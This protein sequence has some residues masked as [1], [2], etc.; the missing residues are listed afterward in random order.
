V[1]RAGLAVLALTALAGLAACGDET[2]TGVGGGL[3][4]PGG[5]VRTFEVFLDGAQYLVRDT[6]FGEYSD[7]RDANFVVVARD[8]EGVLN[9]NA[10]ARFSLPR[11]VTVVDTLGTTQVD[12]MPTYLGGSL[13]VFVDTLRS[14]PGP[15]RLAIYR[16]AERWDESATWE[17][18]RD[19][20]GVRVPWTQP[21]GTRGVFIDTTVYTS[22]RDTLVFDVDGATMAAWA[23]TTDLDR[24]VLIV[25]E[26]AGGRV[27]TS[28]PTLT[29]RLG[30]G[31][32]PDTVVEAS[33]V[34]TAATFMHTPAQPVTASDPRIGGLPAWRTILQFRERLDTLSLPCPGESGVCTLRLIAV[35]ASNTSLQGGPSTP[36]AG[37]RPEGD[38]FVAPFLLLV[39]DR[40]PLQRSPIGDILNIPVTVPASRFVAPAVPAEV[41]SVPIT[42]FMRF[43]ARGDTIAGGIVPT[44][45]TLAPLEPS[46]FG[47]ATFESMPRLRLVVTVA[48]ELQLP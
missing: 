40:L 2:P 18:R 39:S 8:F 9:A 48:R 19:T 42:E 16:T 13:T 12:T 10:L 5:V 33:A 35:T 44:H 15:L 17:H 38:I 3:L 46:A 43:V 26:S 27:R 47:F 37:F 32:N 1:R 14:D 11:T 20:T 4:P 41:V 21:G 31:F 34:L 25:M 36:P 30:S 22:G 28:L 29:A 7:P 24:G 45:L 23:D 6:S